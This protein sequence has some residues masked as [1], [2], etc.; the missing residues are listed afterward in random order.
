MKKIIILI[1]IFVTAL[2]LKA[3]LTQNDVF[4]GDDI[5]WYGLDFSNS[6]F[7][8]M[9]DQFVG[10]GEVDAYDLKNKYVPS[11]NT[12]ILT[13]PAKYDIGK[14]FRKTNV[15]RDI[16]P[17]ERVNKRIDE[18]NM[19]TYNDFCFQDPESLISEAI[20]KYST[21]DKSTGL[22]VVFFIEYFHKE[23]EE[24]SLYVTFFDIG[25]K[26]VLFTERMIGRARG[27]GLRNYWAGAIYNI[28]IQIQKTEFSAWKQKYTK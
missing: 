26:N 28:M 22:G 20:R 7:I 21:G 9:F 3:Q 2:Q 19:M 24:V 27:F 8:G 14:T 18:D 6:K 23:R 10:A 25:T 15:Y 4:T 1:A 16:K 13:E 12:L 17:V 11:W 5:I